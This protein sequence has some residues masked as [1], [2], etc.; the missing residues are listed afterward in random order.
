M[1]VTQL[2]NRNDTMLLMILMLLCK[3]MSYPEKR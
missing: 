3:F 1:Y 2:K